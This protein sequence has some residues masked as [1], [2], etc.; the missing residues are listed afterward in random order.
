MSSMTCRERFRAT[1][2][3]QPVDR[4]PMIEWASWWNKT[5]ERWQGEGL[6]KELWDS[7]QVMGYT[8]AS[9]RRLFRHFGLD[10]YQHVWLHPQGPDCPRAPAH[11]APIIRTEADY[12]RIRPH[13]Y[14]VNIDADAWRAWAAEQAAGDMFIWIQADA[15]GHRAAPVRLL[16]P[17][18]PDAPHER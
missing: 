11:G 13:L 1:M 5:L 15:A 7:S 12:E 17:A 6:P 16:R 10:D 18:G 3:F 8:A 2:N 14:R 4:M 9:R